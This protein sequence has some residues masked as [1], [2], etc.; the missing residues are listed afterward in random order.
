MLKKIKDNRGSGFV[1]GTAF[2][3]FVMLIFSCVMIYVQNMYTIFYIRKE[4][5]E[6]LD[7]YT[8]EQ[9]ELAM[10]NIKNGSNYIVMI[11]GTVLYNEITNELGTDDSGTVYENDRERFK[12]TGADLKYTADDS[13]NTTATVSMDIPVYFM[14]SK[15]L[16]G[17][18]TLV[19]HSK[20]IL[21]AG[22]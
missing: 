1:F 7:R 22:E 17:S 4:A 20:Y 6:T 12:I 21:K 10:C 8:T 18:G 14:N 19:V 13:L 3:L 5:Q 15:I 9:G 16:T 11:D 2:A